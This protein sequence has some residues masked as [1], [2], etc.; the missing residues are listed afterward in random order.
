MQSDMKT[1]GS[2]EYDKKNIFIQVK[3]AFI[4]FP[5]FF[6][7]FCTADSPAQCN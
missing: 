1:I 2:V 6:S 7:L 4:I 5:D 3:P